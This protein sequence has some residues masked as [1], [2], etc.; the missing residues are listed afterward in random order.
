[1]F[2][3][4]GV[5]GVETKEFKERIQHQFD[6]YGKKVLKYAARNILVKYLWGVVLKIFS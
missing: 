2:D 1:M 3:G 5:N 6:A 4:K